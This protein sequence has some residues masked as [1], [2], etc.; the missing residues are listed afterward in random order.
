QPSRRTSCC[1]TAQV[2]KWTC[3]SVKPG[4]TQRPP[5]STTSGLASDVSCTPTPPAT[6]S[7]AIA[8]A[9]DSGN[10]GSSVRTTPFSRIIPG[11]PTEKGAGDVRPRR[12]EREGLRGEPRVLRAGARAA[13][14][15]RRHGLRRVEGGGV[16]QGRPAAVL[17]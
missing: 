5:R 10:D 8:S 17:G 6:R 11:E 2:G 12:A 14:L 3:E 7:P 15:Q 13:R 1:A 4:S 16:R 9:R